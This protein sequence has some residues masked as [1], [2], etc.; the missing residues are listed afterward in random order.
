[1]ATQFV[2]VFAGVPPQTA[3]PPCKQTETHQHNQSARNET[4]YGKKA[5]R[6]EISRCKESY[7]SKCK[8]SG[9]MSD[10]DGQTEKRRMPRRAARSNQVRTHN[11]FAVAW[12]KCVRGS[13]NRGEQ[14]SQQR[15]PRGELAYRN[16]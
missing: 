9:C 2:A 8:H 3:K 5:L 7:E 10:G 4:E 14:Q 13:K 1:M 12:R 11:S 16:D 15:D 6:K